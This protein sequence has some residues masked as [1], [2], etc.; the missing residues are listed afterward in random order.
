[1]NKSKVSPS[2][3]ISLNRAKATDDLELIVEIESDEPEIDKSLSR[4]QKFQIRESNFIQDASAVT[5]AIQEQGGEVVGHAW[6]NQTLR[7]RMPAKAVE[8]LS[9]LKQVTALD[10][11]K[12][13]LPDFDH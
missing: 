1:M 4:Q 3:A 12:S 8:L 2:L 10:I 6:I 11:A 9:K 13:I 7:V 5:R